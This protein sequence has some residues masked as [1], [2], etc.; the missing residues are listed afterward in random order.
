MEAAA[1]LSG[2]PHT[3]RPTCVHPLIAAVARIVNDAVS[4]Q[5]RQRLLRLVPA[6][7]STATTDPGV[8]DDLVQLVCGRGLPVAL[9]IW[10]PALRRALRQAH[11]RHRGFPLTRWQ[12]RRAEAAVRYATISMALASADRDH[13]LTTLLTDC[14]AAV[15]RVND[16]RPQPTGHRDAEPPGV[17]TSHT[18]RS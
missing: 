1:L 10:A 12:L 11:R 3:D 8:V 2:Q 15:E 6:T 16:Q 4:D 13:D 7:I 9:P 18:T 5:A 14:L 17:T